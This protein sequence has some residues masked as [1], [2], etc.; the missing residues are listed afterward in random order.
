MAAD[1]TISRL[2]SD[3]LILIR[4]ECRTKDEL[5]QALATALA[6]AG[7][8]PDPASILKAVLHREDEGMD[9]TLDSG[10]SLP[11][12]RIAGLEQPAAALGSVPDGVPDPRG[13]A[14]IRAMLLLLSPDRPEFY[15]SHLLVLRNV[16]RLFQ[17]SFID[18]LVQSSSAS[19]AMDLI[20]LYE[21]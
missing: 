21:R 18:Q 20:R 19:Q 12:A 3:R 13:L 16:A 11:H 4:P 17:G 2:L 1:E 15:K 7:S 10:L 14:K 6:S 9:T 8:T 5:L